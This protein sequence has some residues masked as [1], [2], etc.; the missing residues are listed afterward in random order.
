[1]ADSV[2]GAWRDVADKLAQ[3]RQ[4]GPRTQQLAPFQRRLSDLSQVVQTELLWFENEK[5]IE[6]DPILSTPSA[7]LDLSLFRMLSFRLWDKV[8]ALGGQLDGLIASAKQLQKQLKDKAAGDGVDI[9]PLIS[10]LNAARDALANVEK[11][12]PEPQPP[13][14]NPNGTLGA[15]VTS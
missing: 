12:I 3:A 8:S 11:L 7:E 15:K 6:F 2:E 10:G 14:L 9:Q 5:E 1:M 13:E 4:A